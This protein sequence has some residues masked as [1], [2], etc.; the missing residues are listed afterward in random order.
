M[1]VTDIPVEYQRMATYFLQAVVL[2]VVVYAAVTGATVT[3]LNAAG[4]LLVTLLPTIWDTD[5]R[6]ALN[7][8]LMLLIMVA[9]TVHAFGASG[10]YSGVHGYDKAAHFLSGMTVALV[11]YAL[12]V[13]VEEQENGWEIPYNHYVF[14]LL[15]TLAAAFVWELW[16]YVVETYSPYVFGSVIITFGSVEDALTDTGFTLLGSLFI[17][18]LDWYIPD[19][20]YVK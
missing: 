13:S 17:I 16:E 15:I 3:A 10:V 12:A 11:G 8:G 5:H 2:G 19:Y 14:I 4:A 18:F 6:E 7:P 9:V 20:D 1:P